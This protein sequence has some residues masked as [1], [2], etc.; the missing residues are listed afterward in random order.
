M[1]NWLNKQVS[2]YKSHADNTGASATF[3]EVLTSKFS[4]DLPTIIALRGLD[5][6][7]D[8]YDIE[9]LN[10]KKKLQCYTPAAL[11]ETKAKGELKEIARTGL[12]QLDF[13]HKDICDFDIEELKRAVFDLPS[14]AFCGLSCSGDGFYALVLIAEPD[15]LS[16]YAEHCFEYFKR[17]GVKADESKGKK[18][19]NLR[20][21]SYDCNMLIRENPEALQIK[22]FKKKQTAQNYKTPGNYKPANTN[23]VLLN[24]ALEKIEQAQKGERWATVQNVAYTIGGINNPS[25]LYELINAINR[26]SA[27]S[28]QEEKYITCARQCFN[29]G[30]LKPLNAG[31]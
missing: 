7:A 25:C 24:R 31:I 10:L 12:M 6:A 22:A 26:N 1:S 4:L 21:L 18:P 3:R 30:S 20:Y 15:R 13:D 16:E 5:R 9:K 8:K 27:F 23:N 17:Y 28:G 19:E 14:V 2:L 29:A 11:L